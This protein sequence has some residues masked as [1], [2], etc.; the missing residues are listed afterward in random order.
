MTYSDPWPSWSSLLLS[1]PAYSPTRMA[2][3]RLISRMPPPKGHSLRF[4]EI[5]QSY[6]TLNI[7]IPYR[8]LVEDRLWIEAEF[9]TRSALPCCALCRSVVPIRTASET[10]PPPRFQIG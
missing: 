10:D 5:K 1:I 4:D 6:L 2:S 3:P 7:Q 8:G 9:A